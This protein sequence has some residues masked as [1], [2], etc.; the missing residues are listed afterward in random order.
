MT[1]ILIIGANGMLGSALLK[2]FCNKN[3]FFVGGTVRNINLLEEL[4]Q[5]KNCQIYEGVDAKN[6]D[7]FLEVFKKFKPNIVI[8]CIGITKQVADINQNKPKD[9]IYINSFLPHY[10][11]NLSNKYKSRFIHMSTDCVFSGKEGNYKE[12]DIADATDLYGR[13]KLLGETYYENSII[14][15][16]SLIGHELSSHQSLLDWFLSQKE[17]IKGYKEAIFSGFPTCEVARIIDEYIIPISTL[18]GLYHVSSEPISKYD[19]LFLV[20]KIYDHKINIIENNTIKINRSLNSTYFNQ[21][22]GFKPKPWNLMI[23]EMKFFN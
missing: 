6:Y 10:L 21:I 11:A 15:R 3:N 18:R 20:K 8:N 4:A 23:E 2:Y 19:L 22:T 7:S 16:T 14:L 17:N 1:K 9:I 13:S 5:K 12:S